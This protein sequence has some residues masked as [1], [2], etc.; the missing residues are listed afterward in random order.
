MANDYATIY[1]FR[2]EL[3][4]RLISEGFEVILSLPS[5]KN[6]SEFVIMG[7]RL[8]E[9][10]L[11][12]TSK[13]PLKD[14]ILLFNYL[15]Q[16]IKFKPDLVFTFTIK[17]NIYGSMACQ[18]TKT[19]YLNNVTGIGSAMQNESFTKKILLLLQKVALS[20][21]NIVYFQNQANK[22]YYENNNI[23]RGNSIL[24]PGSGVNL[25]VNS[26]EDYPIE[27][28]II[29]FI[30]VSRVRK[31]KGFDELFDA[32]KCITQEINNIEFHIVGWCEHTEYEERVQLITQEHPVIFHGKQTQCKVHE[33][34]TDSHCLIHPSHHE[35]MANVILE[36]SATGRPCIVSDISGCREAVD[37]GKT[38]LHFEV[39]NSYDLVEKMKQFIKLEY[40]DKAL[41]GVR[42][43]E[44]ME[45]EFDRNIVVDEYMNNI[46]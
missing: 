35:G 10:K 29:K 34:I 30:I 43:R 27:S 18:L 37:N 11:E 4:A 3:I 32:I 12:R 13:N 5:N 38:G 8:D 20:K 31:D 26:F 17:P 7:C 1:Y 39:K 36:A 42:A 41:M 46:K 28:E 2:R 22:E 23:I 9:I 14:I 45:V 33:L 6:N 24:L 25:G 19:P 16:I 21:A 15:K 44:K 40:K